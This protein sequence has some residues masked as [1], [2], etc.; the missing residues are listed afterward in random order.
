MRMLRVRLSILFLLTIFLMSVNEAQ[1]APRVKTG[2][3]KVNGTRL[4]YEM[5]GRGFPLVFISGGG[6]MDRRCWDEEFASFAKYFRVIR[7]DIRGIGKSERPTS[8]FSHS[9]DLYALLQFLNIKRTN[10]IGL[11]VGGAIGI[12]FTLEHP[13]MVDHLVLAA[14]GVSDDS[15]AEA[16]MQGLTM[17]AALAKK[18]GVERVV[19]L[20]L[21]AP[22]VITKENET[23]RAKIRKI[24]LDNR[25]VFESGFPIYSL[26][27]PTHPPASERLGTI[28]TP[29]LVIRGD[30]DN[31]VYTKMT[32]KIAEGIKG[33]RQVIIPGGT[34]FINLDKPKEFSRAV[35]EFL[36]V[37]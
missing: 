21:D 15:K 9:Q 27:Q 34:H 20:T 28:H 29:T 8:A 2:T 12:D 17:L 4:F 31:P 26:W 23:A 14:P 6:V 25:D 32:D 35:R 11:S 1:S 7:Y 5:K 33:Y 22:F 18:E 19:Q 10:L 37:D 13:E 16:N 36:G 24:Y 30:K 3:A